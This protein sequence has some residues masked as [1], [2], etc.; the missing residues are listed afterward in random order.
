MPRIV[1][2]PKYKANA[3]KNV[4]VDVKAG[5]NMRLKKGYRKK[6]NIK[7]LANK[8]ALLNGEK[9]DTGWVLSTEYAQGQI[10]GTAGGVITSGHYDT[11]L[12]VK[13]S[14]GLGGTQRIGDKIS[15]TGMYNILQ[16]QQQANA[17]QPCKVK[18]IFATPQFSSYSSVVSGASINAI[19]TLLNY[20]PLIYAQSGVQVFDYLCARNQDYIKDWKIL[21]TQTFTIRG[22]TISGQKNTKTVKVGLK[23]KNPHVI[24]YAPGTTNVISGDIRMF[25]LFE[26]GNAGSAV[27][28]GTV[29]SQVSTNAY[30]VPVKDANSGWL[31]CYVSKTYFL[32]EGVLS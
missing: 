3:K 17:L 6:F 27:A 8:V 9:K 1:L 15:V 14:Q 19:E 21:R 26:N 12:A 29:N 20:N 24:H 30:S 32:D 4:V 11:S 18:V 28:N 31:L 2:K 22:D 23:F 25:V 16:F 5:R 7:Q 10:I 13:A